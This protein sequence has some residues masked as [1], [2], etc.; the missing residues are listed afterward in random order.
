MKRAS[1]RLAVEY[2]ALNDEPTIR[3]AEEMIG[4]ASVQLVSEIF[5]VPALRVARDVIRQREA[6]DE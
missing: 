5:D 6:S 4:Y 1:Y 3:G 2:I